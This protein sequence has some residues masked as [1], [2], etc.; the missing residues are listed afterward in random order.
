[1]ALNQ[2]KVAQADV[3]VACD[4]DVIMQQHAKRRGGLL[5][6]FGYGDVGRRWRRVAR[7]VVVQQPTLGHIDLILLFFLEMAISLGPEIGGG[8]F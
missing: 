8:G 7:R 2:S 6:V 5:D 1:M 4:D 3:A